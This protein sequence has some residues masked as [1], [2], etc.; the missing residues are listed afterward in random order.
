MQEQES[1]SDLVA[2]RLALLQE[3]LKLTPE[4]ERLWLAY[5]E[6]TQALAED[7]SRERKRMQ[8]AMSL[9]AMQ[10]V[11]HAVDTARNRLTAWEDIAT[12]ARTL[13]DGLAP[14]QKELADARFPS[15]VAALTGGGVTGFPARPSGAE[16]R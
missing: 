6:R 16:L 15:I 11:A 4:Q 9:N 2:F 10:Q 3:D 12:A 8:S 14:Q 1:V 5:Q 7:I 13:Y